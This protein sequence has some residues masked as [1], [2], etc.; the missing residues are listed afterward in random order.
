MLRRIS[1][2]AREGKAGVFEDA[3][4]TP[5]VRADIGNENATQRR[6]RTIGNRKVQGERERVIPS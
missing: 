4:R 1:E 6:N 3:G 5:S 2:A